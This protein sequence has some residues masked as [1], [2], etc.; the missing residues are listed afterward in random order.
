MQR[1]EPAGHGPLAQ[2]PG[3]GGDRARHEVLPPPGGALGQDRPEG[4][5]G[6]AQGVEVAPGGVRG[7][8]RARAKGYRD[9]LRHRQPGPEGGRPRHSQ[10]VQVVCGRAGGG[11]GPDPG[12]RR[13][14]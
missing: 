8:L 2:G 11:G 14:A 7:G 9:D 4:H 3:Q 12:H 10:Y 13:E 5:R 1:P 6:P